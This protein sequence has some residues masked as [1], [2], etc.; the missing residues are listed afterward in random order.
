MDSATPPAAVGGR[1]VGRLKP[2][3]HVGVEYDHRSVDLAYIDH[4]D[5]TRPLAT[6]SVI[7]IRKL[8]SYRLLCSVTDMDL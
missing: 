5:L 4:L 1:V 3:D 2:L 6:A 8:S 7:T